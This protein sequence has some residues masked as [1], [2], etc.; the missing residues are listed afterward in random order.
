MTEYL[1]AR[2]EDIDDL[3]DDLQGQI[4]TINTTLAG[5]ADI[6]GL[7]PAD[8]AF[9]VGNGTVF[10]TESGATART[11]LGLGTADSPTFVAV[12]VDDLAYNATTWNGSLL[13]PTRN[14]IRDYLE[15]LTGTTLP[16]TYQ[17]LDAELTAIAALAVTDGNFIVG[18]GTTWV[19]ESG[20]TARTSL[21]LGTAAVENIGTSGATVPLLS[22]ANTWSGKQTIIAGSQGLFVGSS[23]RGFLFASD[24]SNTFMSAVNN[25]VDAYRAGVLDALS[26]S[27]RLSGAEVVSIAS[28]NVGIGGSPGAT[29]R[30]FIDA[31]GSTTNHILFRDTGL[32]GMYLKQNTNGSVEMVVIDAASN[33]LMQATGS[34][35]IAG[36]SG[37][38]ELT[39]SSTGLVWNETGGDFDARFEGDTDANLFFLDASADRIGIG[40]GSSLQAKLH[41]RQSAAATRIAYFE[42]TG[43]TGTPTLSIIPTTDTMIFQAGSGDSMDFQSNAGGAGGRIFFT[44]GATGAMVFYDGTGEVA[45]FDGAGSVIFNDT[46]ANCDFRIE[47]D[48]NANLFFLDASTDR[49]GIG[50]ASPATM[51]HVNG[52][53]TATAVLVDD[54]A[55]DATSWNGSLAVPTRNAVRDVIESLVVGSISVSADDLATSVPAFG[56]GA[57][58]NLGITASVG[59]SALTV[60]IKGADGNDPSASNPVLLGFRS[61]TVATGTPVIRSLTAS[62]SLTISSGSTMGTVA[63][64]PFRLA[65][66]IFDDAGTLRLG[67]INPTTG[68]VDETAVASS[69]AEGGA[70]A[71]DSANTY[72]TGSA[73]TSKAFRVVGYLEYSTGLGTAGTWSAAPTII[74]ITDVGATRRTAMPRIGFSATKGGSDQTGV[75]DATFTTVTWGTEVY[76]DGGYFASNT[77]TPPPGLVFVTATFRLSGTMAAG[78]QCA[79]LLRKGTTAILQCDYGS[80]TNEAVVNV[81]AFDYSNG[82]DGYNVQAFANVSSGTVTV[83]GNTTHS[84]FMGYYLAG[85][86]A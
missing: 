65:V 56:A 24:G 70:G 63:N 26:F 6:V 53:V 61:P 39:V 50:T 52:N 27:I 54:L 7:T 84:K 3:D 73:V 57:M 22:T 79:V 32:S 68:S 82:V 62:L 10:V 51:L 44:S 58:I 48:T 76:D 67:L 16:A 41:V 77:W 34:A 40:L 15:T 38:T 59:A 33:I 19:A 30:L 83:G 36:G 28:G 1:F 20:S 31:D 4:D 8:G 5:I 37:A 14:A 42:G 86:F 71:A 35:R 60:A 2:I 23:D 74:Q 49:I 18:N 11:S 69:T 29:N 46:G 9:I 45:R 81:S 75:A 66:V 43:D 12:T 78:S 72:Y 55:Y 64:V 21:G 85:P 47:G 17:P 25:A 80:L 13:V